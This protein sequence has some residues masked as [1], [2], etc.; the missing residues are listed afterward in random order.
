[1][2]SEL[3]VGYGAFVGAC[4]RCSNS[5][6]TCSFLHL[7]IR[8]RRCA[9]RLA[10]YVKRSSNPVFV[11]LKL[12]TVGIQSSRSRAAGLFEAPPA[13]KYPITLDTAR[14]SVSCMIAGSE[15]P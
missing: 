7:A 10:D 4:F 5:D 12:A 11:V 2:A 15:T 8:S 14:C 9:V 6:P 3:A 1:M 13:W